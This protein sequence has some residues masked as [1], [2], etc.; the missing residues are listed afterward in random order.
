MAELVVRF[1]R[2]FL[3]L[4]SQIVDLDDGLLRELEGQLLVAMAER[5]GTAD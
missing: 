3:V 1:C 4:P 5:P 2:S